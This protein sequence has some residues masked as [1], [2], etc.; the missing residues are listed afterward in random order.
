M[1]EPTIEF[2]IPCDLEKAIEARETVT[3]FAGAQ[4]FEG[5]ALQTVRLISDEAIVNAVDHGSALK[6]AMTVD[7][8][9]EAVPDALLL[10][11]RDQGGK[12]FDP[13]YF[14]RLASKKDWGY[15]GRGIALIHAMCD[16]LMFVTNPGVSTTVCI[17]IPR[18]RDFK[19]EVVES[20][21]ND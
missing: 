10:Q 16:E 19:S 7:I 5:H 20:G 13:E 12:V 6:A 11:V 17:R 9:C 3:E 14:Q 1:A 4:G 18:E 8:R 21:V 15:G 2:S